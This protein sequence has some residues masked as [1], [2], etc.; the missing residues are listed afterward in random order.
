MPKG[1]ILRAISWSLLKQ[2]YFAT[3]LFS[4]FKQNNCYSIMILSLEIISPDIARKNWM[5]EHEQEQHGKQN[6]QDII[7]FC[8]LFISSI[9]TLAL[10]KV[11]C[12]YIYIYN[13][14]ACIN[15]RWSFFYS[16]YLLNEF[17]I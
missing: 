2:T 16:I 3:D 13:E 12:V 15:P 14:K 7:K 11:L 6:L 8:F 4:V 1:L 5:K 9:K 10:S 17:C